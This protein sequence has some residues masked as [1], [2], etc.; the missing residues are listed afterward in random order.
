MVGAALER[1]ALIL[2]HADCHEEDTRRFL[3]RLPF[4]FLPF[5]AIAL[6]SQ[7]GILFMG[8]HPHSEEATQ[9]A[10]LREELRQVRSDSALV[11]YTLDQ[12]M[13]LIDALILYLPEGQ[14]MPPYLAEAKH[15]LDVAMDQIRRKETG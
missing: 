5:I 15:R 14:V 11:V 8:N 12:A 9:A 3:H 6:L 7:Y 10:Q 1:P 13:Q 2:T 4:H